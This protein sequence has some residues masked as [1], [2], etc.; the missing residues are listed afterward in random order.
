M[1]KRKTEICSVLTHFKPAAASFHNLS[2]I[3][4]IQCIL[5]II[6]VKRV[7]QD[8]SHSVIQ[9]AQKCV[10]LL[11]KNGRETKKHDITSVTQ[12][13]FLVSISL[14]PGPGPP[15]IW[16]CLGNQTHFSL[17]SQSLHLNPIRCDSDHVFL[18]FVILSQN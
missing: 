17:Q 8:Q 14:K 10:K 3:A 18:R 12:E 4:H 1:V 9:Y 5:Y 2:N 15:T 13:Y 16:V 6:L 7:L 11:K